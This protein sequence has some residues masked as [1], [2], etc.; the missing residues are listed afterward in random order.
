MWIYK[1]RIFRLKRDIKFSFDVNIRIEGRKRVAK[2]VETKKRRERET[3]VRFPVARTQFPRIRFLVIFVV[4]EDDNPN[5]FVNTTSLVFFF[6]SSWEGSDRE[7]EET[8]WF[9]DGGKFSRC[10]DFS[11]VH[12]RVHACALDIISMLFLL[13][14]RNPIIKAPPNLGTRLWCF[15]VVGYAPVTNTM[16]NGGWKVRGSLERNLEEGEVSLLLR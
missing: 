8:G 10:Q 7:I 12:S 13:F 3:S 15:R 4:D 2:R 5:T 14:Q 1:L 6:F 16:H 11:C 9:Q